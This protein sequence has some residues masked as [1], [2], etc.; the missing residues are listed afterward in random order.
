MKSENSNWRINI[1][2]DS[3]IAM[4]NTQIEQVQL[5]RPNTGE[6]RGLSLNDVL[7]MEVSTLHKLLPRITAPALTEQQVSQLDPADLVQIGGELATFFMPKSML[8]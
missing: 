7:N 3:P 6:L 5:R 8:A 4:G 1:K 2:L